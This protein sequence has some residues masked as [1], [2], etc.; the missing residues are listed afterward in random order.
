MQLLAIHQMKLK[1]LLKNVVALKASV[2]QGSAA[3]CEKM[4]AKTRIRPAG[5]EPAA[6]GLGN[7]YGPYGQMLAP[8]AKCRQVL[9][10][11]GL[12]KTA[13]KTGFDR[14]C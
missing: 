7:L 6:P 13:A 5:F 2:F 12:T 14:R 1:R 8:D 10:E 11:K 9:T 3:T 4:Q